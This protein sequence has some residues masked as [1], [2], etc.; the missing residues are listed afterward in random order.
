MTAQFMPITPIVV[1][2]AI[3]LN[4]ILGI[5]YGW[6]YWH[7]GLESAMITHF[8]TD[9]MLHVLLPSLT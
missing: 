3:V 7:R 8:S 6:L 9:I 1:I 2:R 4:G 5:L